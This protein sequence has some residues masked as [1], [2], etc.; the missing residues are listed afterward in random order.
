MEKRALWIP[1]RHDQR[2]TLEA[3]NLGAPLDALRSPATAAAENYLR[4]CGARAAHPHLTW[5]TE[6]SLKLS[7]PPVTVTSRTVPMSRT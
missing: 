3:S 4:T 5:V 7:L 2:A 6:T 1:I